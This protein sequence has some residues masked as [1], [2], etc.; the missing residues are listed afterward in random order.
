TLAIPGF[1]QAATY[2]VELEHLAE[3]DA[4]DRNT[5]DN[6]FIARPLTDGNRLRPSD[7]NAVYRPVNTATVNPAS[8]GRAFAQV[9]PGT[10]ITSGM[11]QAVPLEAWTAQGQP[12]SGMGLYAVSTAPDLLLVADCADV[13][14]PVDSIAVDFTDGLGSVN[15]IAPAMGTQDIVL[16]GRTYTLG[17]QNNRRLRVEN[18]DGSPYERAIPAGAPGALSGTA[19]LRLVLPQ[20]LQA[21]ETINVSVTGGRLACA[22]DFNDACEG[23]M[24]TTCG[25]D[26]DSPAGSAPTCNLQATAGNNFYEF[27]L[28]SDGSASL[29]TVVFDGP[30][31]DPVTVSWSAFTPAS[32]SIMYGDIAGYISYDGDQ[33]FFRVDVT[34]V[35]N[36]GLDGF[37]DFPAS[38]VDLRVSLERGNRTLPLGFSGENTDL[39]PCSGGATDDPDRNTCSQGALNDEGRGPQSTNQCA[40]QV[41][42]NE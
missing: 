20:I 1:D 25:R 38:P 12:A 23:G 35:T 6:D 4:G 29:A 7:F 3:P 22:V 24:L 5:R 14:M 28:L 21:E 13:T 11:C 42:G 32:A 40:Y 41:S 30:N 34:G 16:D 18:P 10:V 36:A 2:T 9:V 8:G 39:V 33:D 19:I 17:V 26:I 27:Q 31:F 37:V 15:L